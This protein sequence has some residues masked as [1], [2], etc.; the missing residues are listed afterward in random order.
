MSKV[1]EGRI[2][3]VSAFM[4]AV[5][6]GKEPK[7]VRLDMVGGTNYICGTFTFVSP[8]NGK[9]IDEDRLAFISAASSNWALEVQ[10][11]TEMFVVVN[12]DKII[13]CSFE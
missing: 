7:K 10:T 5:S 12:L 1:N 8:L 3:V 4:R 2:A 6:L 11:T 13:A 9:P